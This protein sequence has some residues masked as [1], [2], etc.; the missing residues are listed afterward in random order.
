VPGRRIAV[1]D[2]G[3]NSTR[4]LVAEVDGPR[5]TE[6]VRE[7]RVTRLGEGV[8]ASG[9]LGDDAVGRVFDA[10]EA[11]RRAIDEADAGEVV[12]VATSAVRDADNG[13]AFRDELIERF[14][15]DAHT[16][17]GDEEARLTF[18]GATADA[19][20][21]GAETLVVDIGGGSTEFVSGRPG[22]PPAFHVSTQLGSVRQTERHLAGDPPTAGQ[23]SAL[24]SEVR[25]TIEAEVPAE[26]RRSAE[27]GIAVAGTATS[28]AAI[29]QRLD[30]Y[31][32]ERVHGYGLALTACEE[33]L[34][35][36][37]G[38]TL[39]RRRQ[40]PGLHPDR[41]PTIVAGAA[42]LVEA[43]RAFGLRQMRASEWDILHGAALE[44]AERG[45]ESPGGHRV[46]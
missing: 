4:V 16:I 1:V 31:D 27:A 9:R 36:L 22:E 5:L 30:P 10:L 19:G 7:T 3:T 38:L 24:S 39:E 2:L 41:A 25:A 11:F 8:D 33:M 45:D 21:G 29:D 17:S 46:T 14:G 26:V 15:I 35:M 32:P 20:R 34:A 18:R 12:G 40:V 13:P 44:A 37:S 23:M 6:L 43:M 42:I 28:L